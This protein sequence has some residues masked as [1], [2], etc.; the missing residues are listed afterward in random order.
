MWWNC[1]KPNLR[2]LRKRLFKYKI[3]QFLLALLDD[4]EDCVDVSSLIFKITNYC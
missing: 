3:H 1:L 2:K 4:E